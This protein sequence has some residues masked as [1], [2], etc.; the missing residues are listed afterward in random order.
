M[1][2]RTWAILLPPVPVALMAAVSTLV[3]APG[4]LARMSRVL[5]LT[6][7][8]AQRFDFLLIGALLDI[9]VI[10]HF[11]DLLQITKQVIELVDH[12]LHFA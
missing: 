4:L 11:R 1:T 5:E 10:Q 3:I 9:D 2:W 7:S 12:G 8:I 6:Q